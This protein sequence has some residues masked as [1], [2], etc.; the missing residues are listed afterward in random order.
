VTSGEVLQNL[1][2]SA[3]VRRMSSSNILLSQRTS[4]VSNESDQAGG[5]GNTPGR[6]NNTPEDT[7][8]TPDAGQEEHDDGDELAREFCAHTLVTTQVA[9]GDMNLGC[10]NHTYHR[11]RLITCRLV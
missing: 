7:N 4:R 3:A 9:E 8:G 10:L 2:A 11:P 6:A 1:D 5:G